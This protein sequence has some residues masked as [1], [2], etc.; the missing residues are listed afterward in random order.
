MT[1]IQ[2]TNL[3]DWVFYVRQRGVYGTICHDY[4]VCPYVCPSVTHVL[5]ITRKL[6]YRK[7]DRALRPIHRCPEYFRDSL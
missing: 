1:S 2:V 7:D 3:S 4:S 6:C 5:C